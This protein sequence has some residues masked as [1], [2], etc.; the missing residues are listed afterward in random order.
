MSKAISE[1]DR[2]S[3]H[4]NP[5]DEVIVQMEQQ[6]VISV[7]WYLVKF[8]PRNAAALAASI[9]GNLPNKGILGSI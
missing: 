6:F 3:N 8:V 2:K 4:F 7:M 1:V 9:A 5:L